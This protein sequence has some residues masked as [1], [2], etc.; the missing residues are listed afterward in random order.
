MDLLYRCQNRMKEAVRA[1][2]RLFSEL[3]DDDS[4][5]KTEA[6]LSLAGMLR[7]MGRYAESDT[8]LEE[9][10]NEVVDE[11]KSLPPV[12]MYVGM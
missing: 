7:T 10:R 4:E 3:A 8:I 9:R 5:H 12:C 6:A 11:I 1:A 2:R